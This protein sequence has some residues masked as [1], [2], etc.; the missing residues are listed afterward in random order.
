MAQLQQEIQ[1]L[2]STKEWIP[3]ARQYTALQNRIVEMEARQEARENQW[4]EVVE[5][6][7][8]VA[9]MQ[10][11]LMRQRWEMA[12]D[13]KNSELQGFRSELDSILQTAM[14]LKAQQGGAAIAA[15]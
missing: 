2:K 15:M 9:Q 8:R 12:L 6:T 13:A 10:Q 5:E 14:L 7:K 1:H 4:K 3:Q 11:G